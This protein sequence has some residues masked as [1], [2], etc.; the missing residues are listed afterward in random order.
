MSCRGVP[1]DP[2]YSGTQIALYRL[3]CL[4]YRR[5][6]LLATLCATPRTVKIP[7]G[8][9]GV[10]L[11]LATW[12]ARRRRCR[13]PPIRRTAPRISR[14]RAGRRSVSPAYRGS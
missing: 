10:E 3:G 2:L 5:G 12:R 8:V 7:D 9:E 4:A 6:R 1:S 11:Y 13:P 14:C